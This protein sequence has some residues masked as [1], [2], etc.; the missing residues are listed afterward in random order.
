MSLAERKALAR[1]AA[2]G[3]RKAAFAAG[4]GAATDHLLAWL[5][6]HRGRPIAGYMPIRTEI[7]PRA[8]M[9]AMAA[10]GP[11]AVPVIQGKG[12]P[13]LFHRWTPEIPMVEGPFGAMVPAEGEPIAPQVLI[14]PLVAFRRDGYRLGYGG[15]FYDRSLEALRAVRPTVAV[16]FAFAAQE[17]PDLPLEPTDQ[18][19]DAIVTEHGVV[20]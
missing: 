11:V 8:A 12:R 18:P 6:P 4:Q 13:L 16:G 14:A 9:A 15:G 7:D 19:L 3:R 10:F 2:F 5:A 20:G 1:K 17:D